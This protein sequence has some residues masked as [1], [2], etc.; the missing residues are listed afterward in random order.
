MSTD[1]TERA[2]TMWQA[3]ERWEAILGALRDEGYSKID[4]IKATVEQ[5]RLP[6]ADAKR[7]VHESPAWAEVQREHDVLLDRWADEA[8]RGVLDR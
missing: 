5:L 8:E 1:V 6:L 4:C 2:S 7:I 3:G